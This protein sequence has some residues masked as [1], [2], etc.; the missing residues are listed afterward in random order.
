V[1]A[2]KEAI[3]KWLKK[4]IIWEKDVDKQEKIAGQLM[5]LYGW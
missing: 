1:K 2:M 5:K 3:R 4:A